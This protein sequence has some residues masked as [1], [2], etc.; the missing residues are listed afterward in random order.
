MRFQRRYVANIFLIFA[1]AILSSHC[2]GQA[3]SQ[4]AFPPLEQ[5]KAAVI[6][7]N[8]AT[9]QALYSSNPPAQVATGA[10]ASSVTSEV[11]FWTG[12]KARR[13][14][15]SVIQSE[16]SQTGVQQ[17]IF[18]A[19]VHTST[20]PGGRTL[21]VTEGQLWQMQGE[22]WRIVGTKRSD[23]T[24]LQQPSSTSKVIYAPGVDAHAEIKHA[25]E[26]AAKGHKRV[27]VV[28]GANWCYDCHV[29]D[30]AFHRPD[31]AGVLQ[32]NFEVVHVDV[33]EGDKNQDIM[34]DYQVPMKRGI[35]AV[36]VLDGNGKLLYS[37]KGGE[38]ERARAL[39]PEDVVQ[40]LNKWKP[41]AR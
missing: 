20:G 4:P 38:F 15:L 11:A 13:I 37:Q 26:L 3:T 14:N 30:L 5:W 31:V 9:L 40:F 24:K 32:Q 12:L 18:E 33:G 16:S 21:Y 23:A 29:L 19:E 2:A 25:L 39:A 28:F 7:G 34:A 1:M 36:A 41:V 27:L 17:V 35:P 10:G 22:Q 6:S 8:V